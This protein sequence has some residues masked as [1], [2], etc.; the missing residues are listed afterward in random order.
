MLAVVLAA[1]VVRPE[2]QPLKALHWIGKVKAISAKSA[3]SSLK[4]EAAAYL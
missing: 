2:K 1:V 3:C 4:P